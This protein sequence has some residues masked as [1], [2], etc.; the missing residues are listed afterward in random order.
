MNVGELSLRP[1]PELDA[2]VAKL[3]SASALAE[4]ALL[5]ACLGGA[6]LAVRLIRGATARPGSIWFGDRIVDGVLFPV[7]ALGAALL[8]RWLI[9]DAVPV[10][11]FRLAVPILSSLV[12]IRVGVRVL[13]VAF[14]TSAL[15]RA[16]ERTL[17]W[18]VWVGL[19]LWLTGLLPLIVA[20]LDQIRWT[21]G[22]TQVSVRALVEGALTAIVVLVFALWVSAAIESRLLAVEG[23]AADELSL[24][25]IAANATRALLLLVGLL[26]ALSAAG[27]PLGALGVLGGAI[28]VGIGF[29]LQK[30]AAN[31]V[32]GFVI[33]AE[34]SLRIGDL[35]RVDNFE[36][37]ITDITTRYTVI[38]S[39]GGR[40][41]IVPNEMLITSRIENLSLA[42]RNVLLNTV[43][44]V[45]YGTDVEPVMARLADVV[46]AVPRVLADP[47]P[48]VRLTNFAADGLELTLFFWIADPEN[49]QANVRSE[50]NLAVLRTLGEMGI[51]IPFPQRVLHLPAGAQLAR[52]AS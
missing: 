7:L 2:F 29:G 16:L 13:H 24:R 44:Q 35:V 12:I 32:S 36:G 18:F 46:R 38:R 9:R 3:F 1:G 4:L 19:V 30:L 48:S 27:I 6:W 49:G 26:I 31:Y 50:V 40:E 42:D 5:A 52:P 37:Q 33:L 51:E 21:M 17:S 41:S 10:A 47:A 15:V 34:R 43:V 22:G 28:G 25:K 45:P 23:R 39:L 14:P 20:E 8:V 11:V